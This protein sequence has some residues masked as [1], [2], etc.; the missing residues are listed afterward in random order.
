MTSSKEPL[1]P[2][3]VLSNFSYLLTTRIVLQVVQMLDLCDLWR[4]GI[5]AI[6]STKNKR[7][8]TIDYQDND[9]VNGIRL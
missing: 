6:T 3:R 7:A 8:K 1:K 9:I 2:I 4:K 5:Y